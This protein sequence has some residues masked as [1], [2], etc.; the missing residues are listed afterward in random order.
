MLVSKVESEGEFLLHKLR[1]FPE[2][3]NRDIVF[4][5]GRDEANDREK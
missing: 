1:Q 4:L 2:L 3:E 5:S